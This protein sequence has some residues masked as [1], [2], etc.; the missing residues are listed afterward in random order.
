[1]KTSIGSRIP[2][3]FLELKHK[4]KLINELNSKIG[5]I[6]S[7]VKRIIDVINSPILDIS[8]MGYRMGAMNL[9]DVGDFSRF[10]S[11]NK[12]LAYTAYHLRP[13]KPVSWSPRTPTQKNG[14]RYLRFVFCHLEKNYSIYLQKKISEENHY[15]IAITHTT[16]KLVWLIYAT[17]I[18]KK[19]CL[20]AT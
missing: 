13:I 14:S 19:P 4:L 6:E 16:R 7:E 15:N 18:P 1:M 2:A 8:G 11:P 9:A 12:L 3:K 10:D 5:K 20:K 17:K